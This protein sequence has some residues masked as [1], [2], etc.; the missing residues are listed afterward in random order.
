M[1]LFDVEAT[2]A[3]EASIDAFIERRAKQNEEQRCVEKEWAISE[4]RHRERRQERNREL[5]RSW[6]L[7]QAE[8]LER[9]AAEL[10]AS[11]R[12]KAEVLAEVE[13]GEGCLVDGPMHRY[14]G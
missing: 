9:T 13:E 5:W 3:V 10:A 1:D 12:S 6:H 14:K 2:E 8:R 7:G 11:H 4:R